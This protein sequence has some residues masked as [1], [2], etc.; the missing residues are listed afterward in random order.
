[1]QSGSGKQIDIDRLKADIAAAGI[2]ILSA[3]CAVDRVRRQY[4][5]QDIVEFSEPTTLKKA[6]ASSQALCHFFSLLEV[7]LRNTENSG[8]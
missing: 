5:P 8:I 7:Q 1:M 6:I 3:H 4:S 2:E